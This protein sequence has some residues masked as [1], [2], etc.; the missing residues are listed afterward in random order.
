MKLKSIDVI[1][2]EI[3]LPKP[4]AG[5]TY[6]V[7][8]R[9][10]VITRITTDEGVTSEVFN[11]DNRVSG[12][13]IC[14]IV[15]DELWPL[16]VGDD[17]S[18]SEMIWQ[19]M[20]KMTHAQRNYGLWMEAIACIDTAIWD[21]RGKSLGIS[22]CN[23]AGGYT[24]RLKVIATGGYYAK[25]KSSKDIAEEMQYLQSVGM[26]G[27]K[28]KVGGL[29]PEEDIERVAAAREGAGPEFA[30]GCDAN[31]GWGIDEAIRFARLAEPLNVH[32]F[33]EPCHW[34]DDA[35]MMAEVRKSTTIPINAGQSEIS[36]LGVR[37]L[38]DAG[39]VDWINFDM[40]HGGGPTE[41]RRAANIC[42]GAG[43]KMMHH[44]ESQLTCHLL[45]SVPHG[46]YVDCFPD[47]N[48]DPIWDKM[49]IN[50]PKVEGGYMTVPTGPGFDIQ[51]DQDMVK[52]YT[53]N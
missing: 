20:F 31:R 23:L 53:K 28:F 45:A 9:C 1:S 40:S 24:D 11:G 6:T 4:M 46:L 41:W 35:S 3:P 18:Q 42:G 43:V 37:R 12:L 52:K 29:S 17:I 47:P 26:F 25:G 50:R 33:E 32:W 15:H 5:A 34:H 22:V 13:E 8:S 16:I 38:L 36:S 51:L 2:I 27:I 10:T 49:W 21:L 19:K 30:I 39:A 44:E 48:R 14:R 7:P